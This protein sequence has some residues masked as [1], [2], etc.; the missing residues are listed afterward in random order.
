MNTEVRSSTRLSG[1]GLFAVILSA[2]STLIPASIGLV[3]AGTIK[4]ANPAGVDVTQGLAYLREIL[5]TSWV[6]IGVF[7]VAA[8]I[9]NLLVMKK[10]PGA[11]RLAFIV[12]G[13]QVVCGILLLLAMG[14]STVNPA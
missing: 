4:R 9:V 2:A 11:G 7:V 12:L 5:I 13:T 1:A 3:F 6:A 14:F 8:I 10:D